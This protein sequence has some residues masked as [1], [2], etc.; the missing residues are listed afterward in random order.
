MTT[1]TPSAKSRAVIASTGP[2]GLRTEIDA[3]GHALVADEPVTVGGTDTG[4]S[5]YDL[6][7]A[8]LASCTS[9]TLQLYARHREIKLDK[10]TVRVTHGK[11]HAV[12]CRDC[13]KQ[14]RKI[15]RFV[16][17]INLEGEIDDAARARLLE[18]ADRCPVHRS[19]SG[20][21]EILTELD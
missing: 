1:D 11:V 9:M 21:I 14:T 6:L 13:E 10:V 3:A 7:A 15:D 4:P 16:R 12:D 8:A 2:A 20:E 5:P 19:L 18:I 17:L